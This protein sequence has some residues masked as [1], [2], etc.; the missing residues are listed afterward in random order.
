[1][2]RTNPH[3]ARVGTTAHT[4]SFCEFKEAYMRGSHAFT[5]FRKNK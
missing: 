3:W 1:M 4:L 5:D 2:E